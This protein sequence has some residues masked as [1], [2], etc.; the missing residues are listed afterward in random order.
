MNRTDAIKTITAIQRYNRRSL[1]GWASVCVAVLVAAIL[2]VVGCNVY[3]REV[4]KLQDNPKVEVLQY[5]PYIALG[6]S[7][8][9]MLSIAVIE[10]EL[11]RRRLN[12]SRRQALDLRHFVRD[13]LRH[14]EEEERAMGQVLHD[15]I[16]GGLTVLKMELEGLQRGPVATDEDWVRCTE[17]LETLLQRVRGIAR[18]FFP[19][20][21]GQAR[22]SASLTELVERLSTEHCRMEQDVDCLVDQLPQEMNYR[23][24]RLVQESLIN[25]L[26]HADAHR[27][28][29]KIEVRGNKVVGTVDDDG[30]GWK[31][32]GD[33]D[34]M[35]ITLMRELVYALSGALDFEPSPLGGARVSFVLPIKEGARDEEK[36]ADWA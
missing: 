10:V 14:V 25:V 4:E 36:G 1:M 15:E 33:P 19:N 12:I 21:I 28:Q 16:G 8:I 5:M 22:L 35:G 30:Q 2:L 27:V 23:V 6:L 34:G 20:L 17:Q 26:R 18:L 7:T 31:H 29:L 32:G 3:W 24:F 11:Y 13:T 9:V